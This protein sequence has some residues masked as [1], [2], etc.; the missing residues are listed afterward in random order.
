M[1]EGCVPTISMFYGMYYAPGEHKPAHFHAYYGEYGARHEFQ[2][3]VFTDGDIPARQRKL[4]EAW[5]ELHKDEL[6]ADW[7]LVMNGEEPFRITPL[8]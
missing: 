6:N 1:V 2:N 7:D 4:I 5:A 8:L 3:G